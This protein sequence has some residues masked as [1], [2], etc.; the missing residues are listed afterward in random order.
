MK[1]FLTLLV[2]IPMAVILYAQSPQKMSFQAVV[3]NSDGNLVANSTVGVRIQILQTSEFGSAVYVET[4]TP[5]TNINGL[6]TLE[7]GAGNIVLGTFASIDWANGPYFIKVETDITGG[8]SYTITGV[9][10]ILSVPYALSAKTAESITGPIN[11]T[12]DLTDVL[13]QGNNAGANQIKNIADPSDAQDA[14][15]KEY[16]DYFLKILGIMPNNYAGL[17]T[18]IEGNQYIIVTIGTQ[19]W[20]EQNLKTTKYNDGTSIPLVSDNTAWSNLTAPGYC[21]SN[22]IFGAIYNW[23]AVNTGKLCPTGWHVPAEADWTTLTNYLGG[24][25]IAGDKLKEIGS[26]HWQYPGTDVANKTTTN[27]SGF[28]AL[29]GGYRNSAG[30]FGALMSHGFFWSAT[31][32]DA[33]TAW[34]R[35]VYSGD[36]NLHIHS[37]YTKNFGFSVRCV[38]D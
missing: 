11:E 13:G 8:T 22:P 23:Y 3:R 25:T 6:M 32:Y 20:M 10:Q 1:R 24:E 38:K 27:E 17:M 33:T 4:H 26:I 34:C 31:E 28:S 19:T 7:I 14:V 36:G 18:D 30:G 35:F 29:P 9:S 16:V 2:T 5:T 37:G 21:W 12:Q 15:S